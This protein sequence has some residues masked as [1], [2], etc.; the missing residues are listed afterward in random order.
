MEIMANSN[1]DKSKYYLLVLLNQFHT[2]LVKGNDNFQM[3]KQYLKIKSQY[4]TDWIKWVDYVV[5][6][7]KLDDEG[8]KVFD[9]YIKLNINKTLK[10][11]FKIES[12]TTN[13]ME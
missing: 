12:L 8:K 7:Y 1:Y 6:T 4:K 9:D 13:F 3:I 5:K 10:K 11:S 2:I